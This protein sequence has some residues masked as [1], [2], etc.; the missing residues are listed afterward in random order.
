MSAI[1][2]AIIV[3]TLIACVMSWAYSNF[4]RP[5]MTGQPKKTIFE[6]QSVQFFLLSMPCNNLALFECIYS[7]ENRNP[8]FNEDNIIYENYTTEI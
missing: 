7:G 3:I 6:D 4:E 1:I 8:I 2:F 5:K